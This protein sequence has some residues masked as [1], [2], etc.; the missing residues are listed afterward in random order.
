MKPLLYLMLGAGLLVC[1]GVAYDRFS[2]P[3]LEPVAVTQPSKDAAPE[4]TFYTARGKPLGVQQ[5]TSAY[6]LVH[7]WATWC[8]PC[9]DELPVIAELAAT[10]GDKLTILAVSV[11]DASVDIQHYLSQFDAATQRKFSRKNIVFIRDTTQEAARAYQS[12]RYPESYLLGPQRTIQ[13]KFVGAINPRD[14][15]LQD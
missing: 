7:F 8:A 2:A 9:K 3:S 14:F 13:R 1:A 10:Y 11:D 4:V 6:V 12:Y 15:S 5:I